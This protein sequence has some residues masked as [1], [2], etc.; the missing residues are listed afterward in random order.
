MSG[1]PARRIRLDARRRWFPDLRE[2]R[3][4]RQLVVLLGRRDITV[5]YRQTVLGSIWIFA[6]ALVTAG[7]FSFVFGRI[8]SL[9]TGGVPYFLFSY[10]GLFGWNLFSGSLSSVSGS[11]NPNAGLIS[12]IYFPRLVLPLST[13]ASTIVNTAL[14]FVIM[15]VLL[16]LYGV[17]VTWQM[18]LLPFWLVLGIVLALGV[19]LFL[20]AYSVSFRDVGYATPVLI[21]VLLYLSPVAYSLEAVPA[22]LRNL[23]LLNPLATILEGTRWALLGGSY[24]PPAWAIAYAVT[25]SVL[26]L[27]IGAM[28]FARREWGFADVI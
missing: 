18:L 17:A 8:A 7:L 14:S 3:R 11:L 2:L 27:V 1:T 4:Y 21:S 10:A 13:L 5:R 22:G 12:K 16:F 9:P 20:A 26:S 6:G 23:Y 15:L 28:V 24:L 25:F 19:G